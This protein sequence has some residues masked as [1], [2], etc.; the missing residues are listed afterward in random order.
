MATKKHVAAKPFPRFSFSVLFCGL[1]FSASSATFALES[2]GED[3][4]RQID[5]QS[6]ITLQYLAPGDVGNSPSNNAANANIGFYK[7]GMEAVMELNANINKLQLGCG[8][9]F[10]AGCDIDI[11][12]LSLSGLGNSATSNTD[13]GANRLARAGSS[14]VLTNPFIQLAIQNPNSASTRQLAGVNF[15]AESI[16]G[17]MTF[18]QENGAIENGI[19]SLSG[20]MEVAQAGGTAKVN[21]II[22][23]RPSDVDNKQISG[24][25]CGYLACLPFVTTDYTLNLTTDVAGTSTAPFTGSL[26]L[27]QQVITG[28]RITAAAL[29]ATAVVSGIKVTGNIKAQAAGLLNLDK[30]TTGAIDG[31]NVNVSINEDLGYF[32]KADLNGSA[33]SLSV[34]GQNILWPSN[35]SVSQAGW[36]LELSNPISIGDI[37]PVDPVDIAKDTIKDTLDV[38]SNKLSTGSRGNTKVDCG[39]AGLL[40]CVAGSSIN[41]GNLDLTSATP[42]SMILNNLQLVNQ[43]FTPNCYGGLKFC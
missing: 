18:G 13:T 30:S 36:W 1:I 33:A 23:L 42:V 6:L 37:S 24:E 3:A 35:K 28:K 15:S 14:A 41:M 5:G 7:L 40:S 39:A 31:L 10:G 19:N 9:V 43:S 38:V 16:V 25:A 22:G 20:Y 21:S 32:H 11:D 17:L 34:Q 27:P 8:G 26:V 12:N 2:L 29:T 4:M